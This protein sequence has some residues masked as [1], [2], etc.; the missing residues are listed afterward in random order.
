MTTTSSL[1]DHIN[2]S[3]LTRYLLQLVHI[4]RLKRWSMHKYYLKQQAIKMAHC[5]DSSWVVIWHTCLPFWGLSM[6]P[7]SILLK[8]RLFVTK[9]D[10]RWPPCEKL[11]LKTFPKLC[12]F[13]LLYD[14]LLMQVLLFIYFYSL[15]DRNEM[16]RVNVFYKKNLFLNWSFFT[17]T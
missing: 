17:I 10:Q 11:S 1:R 4:L 7:W 14:E 2:I 15:R 3:I 16:K 9:L 6:K 13:L 12:S 8:L 5:R